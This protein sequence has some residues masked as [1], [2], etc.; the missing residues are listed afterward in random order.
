[1]NARRLEAS[2]PCL[3]VR[4]RADLWLGIATSVL[5]SLILSCSPASKGVDGVRLRGGS[6]FRD[7]AQ[8]EDTVAIAVYSPSDCLACHSAIASWQRW[9]QQSA[10]TRG[11][12]VVLSRAAD[13]VE[14]RQLSLL[15]V[16][17]EVVLHRSDDFPSLPR[18][19][20]AVAG[21]IT[22]SALGGGYQERSLVARLSRR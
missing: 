2:Y 9:Q 3:Q 20:I 19:Y 5:A 10:H 12:I 11:F 16:E 6:T 7:L 1:M 13:E 14:S 17:T 8:A 22:D 4:S 15:R 21:R 18:V